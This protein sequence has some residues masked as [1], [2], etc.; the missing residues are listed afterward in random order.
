MRA[1][2]LRSLVVVAIGGLILAGVLYVASTVDGRPP[3]VLSIALTQPLPDEPTRGLSTTSLEVTFTEPVE[4]ESAADALVIE[5]RVAG[6]ISWS[7]N[8]MIFTPSEPLALATAYAVSVRGGV[9]DLAGNRMADEPPPFAFET[10]GP[11]RVVETQPAEGETDVALEEP[12]TVRF[13]ALMDT[14]SVEA[15]LR[16]RPMFSHEVRWSGELLEIVPTEPLRAE[17]HYAVEIGEAAFDVSGVALGEPVELGFRT[18]APGLD[19]SLVTP[20]DGSDGIA[21]TAP[22]AI[23]FDRPIDP[24]PFSDDLLSITPDVAGSLELVDELGNQPAGPEEGQVLR[25]TPA[26]ALPAN[27][28][29]EVELAP[30]ISALSGGGLAVPVRW[31]FTTGAPHTTL[32]NQITFLSDRAGVPNLWAMNVDGS[33]AHQV[34]TELTPI[35]DYAV[36]P[37]GTSFVVGDGRRLIQV[38]ADGENRRVLTEEGFLE[39]DATYAPDGESLAFARADAS[40]GLGL[41]IWVRPIPGN[42]AE[43]IQVPP[44][45]GVP[46]SPTA[47]GQPSEASSWLRA[48]RYAPDGD[49]LAFVDPGGWVGIADLS[50]DLLTRVRYDARAAPLWLPDGSGLLLTGRASERTD[51]VAPLEAPVEPLAPNGTATVG[52]LESSASA[53]EASGFGQGASAEAVSA[54][55]RIAYLGSDGSLRVTDD[56]DEPGRV[57]PAVDGERI[58]AAAFAPGEDSMVVVVLDDAASSASTAEGRI[59]RIG[60]ETVGREVL[61]NDGWRPRWLP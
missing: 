52:V 11:P 51:D 53:V 7:G 2:F 17:T 60:V 5:P 14:A 35:L 56:P 19:I 22:L 6:S 9:E 36:S 41:G 61:A 21:P 28:T 10:T 37:D 8:V 44:D 33:A 40:T 42:A 39:F 34:S 13:S 59:E 27:T 24:A 29:F 26:G 45:A 58:S 46:E 15:A 25:F 16:L 43:P 57:P 50:S 55:G 30:G 48:P 20:A 12:I 23:F 31:T 49:A 47:S 1:V 54:D 18:L 38:D 32:S 3:A 4:R